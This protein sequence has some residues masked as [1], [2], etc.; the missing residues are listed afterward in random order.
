MYLTRELYVKNWDHHPKDG[1]WEITVKRGGRLIETINPAKISGVIEEVG[2][3]RKANQ[4]HAWFVDRVQEGVD[5]CQKSYVSSKQ[6]AE[7]LMVC[8]G[9]FYLHEQLGDTPEV[10]SAIE[11]RLPPREGFFFGSTDVNDSFWEDIKLTIGI[12]EPLVGSMV[13]RPRLPAAVVG[14]SREGYEL[15]FPAA[16]QGEVVEDDALIGDFYYQSSW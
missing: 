15:V 9:L 12:L 11:E 1:R 7:L 6:L 16:L 2:Y 13:A 8:R 10:L 14:G 5:E 4:I 3:W